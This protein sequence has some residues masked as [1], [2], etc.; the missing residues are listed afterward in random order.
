MLKKTSS[1]LKLNNQTQNEFVFAN[2][3]KQFN[4]EN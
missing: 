3:E 1:F 4:N 2:F